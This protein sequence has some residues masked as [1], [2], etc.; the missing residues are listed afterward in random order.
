MVNFKSF[1]GILS[2]FF[3]FICMSCHIQKWSE[4]TTGVSGYIRQSSG[5]QMPDPN[6]P[7]S[8]PPALQATVY[9]FELTPLS[10]TERIGSS[11]I[12]RKVHTK[13]IDSVK[14]DKL[15]YYQFNHD[16]CL[17]RTGL[18]YIATCKWHASWLNWK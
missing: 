9:V 2:V 10:A 7:V 16:G 5:N 13:F 6:E 14:S 17:S 18:W 11:S 3:V 1:G 8:T 12:F 15:G 4:I